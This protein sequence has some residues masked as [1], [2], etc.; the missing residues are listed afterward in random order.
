MTAMLP[1]KLGT[2][3]AIWYA[4]LFALLLGSSALALFELLELRLRAEAD[5]NLIDHVAGLWG[6]VEFHGEKP[7]LKYDP[8][9]KYLTYFLREATRYYQIYDAQSGVLLLESE[10]S[11]LMQLSLSP[12]Q[13]TKIVDDPGIDTLTRAQASLRFRSAVFHSNGHAYLVRVGVS[14]EQDL[15]I[16]SEL[17]KVLLWLFPLTSTMALIAAWWMSAHILRP[18]RQLEQEA[19]AISITQL[20][21]RLPQ[22]GTNDELDSLAETFNRVLARLDAS[23]RQMRDFA[24]FMAHEL[25]TPMTVLRGEVQ[26]E[27]MRP[28]LPPEWR[29][30]L[31]SHLEEFGK[32]N[33]LIDRFLLLAK[34]ETGGIQ[35]HKQKVSLS[36]M[37]GALVEMLLPL[38]E[39]LGIRLS[40]ATEGSVEILA[41]M[42]WIE[43]ALL[44][45]LDNALKFTHADGEVSIAVYHGPSGAVVE[46]ADTG[47]GISPKDLPYIFERFYRAEE[48]A[49]NLMQPGGI[50]LSLTRWIIEQHQGTI[51]VKSAK[52]QGTTFTVVL[53][54]H[55][56]EGA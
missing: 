23:V 24:D 26:V 42:E 49:T 10:D 40:I 31:E 11:A 48:S 8:Q 2:K 30:H 14:V 29:S 19:N 34:A 16:L 45:L 20:N 39:S 43:R 18:L 32:L 27:L 4:L 35:F 50:G 47:R 21:R 46:I 33:R 3:L 22:R 38:A 53:P 41:D 13:I 1:V 9:N 36:D 56:Q 37:A 7:V 17:R 54:I 55:H 5:D 6:Y 25:R 44:N 51:A 15:E 28:D 52:G 12:A